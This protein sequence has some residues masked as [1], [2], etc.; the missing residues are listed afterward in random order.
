MSK[1]ER[2]ADP[3]S[4]TSHKI[5]D[6]R[7]MHAQTKYVESVLERSIQLLSQALKLA[8]GFER[9]KLG[10][11]QRA[12]KLAKDDKENKRLLAEIAALKVGSCIQDTDTC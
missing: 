3:L 7:D 10:R 2:E 4:D 9:Q 6:H 11:R 8:R 5:T 12:I 1:R